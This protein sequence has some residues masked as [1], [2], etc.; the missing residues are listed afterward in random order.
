MSPCSTTWE[1]HNFIRE[2]KTFARSRLCTVSVL[3]LVHQLS[4]ISSVLTIQSSR[5]THQVG[6]FHSV[7][8]SVR[9]TLQVE[10]AVLRHSSPLQAQDTHLT[11][12]LHRQ[13]T[14]AEGQ[15]T[16]SLCHGSWA[17]A[18]FPLMLSPAKT[19]ATRSSMTVSCQQSLFPWTFFVDTTH[20]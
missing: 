5:W 20:A 11:A 6:G 3:Q 4:I 17:R 16:L 12:R 2:Q 14:P 18:L 10:R 15:M 19:S 9:S 1:V 8:N 13:A 7:L